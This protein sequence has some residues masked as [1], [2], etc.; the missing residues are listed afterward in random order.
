MIKGP[1]PLGVKEVRYA[2][3]RLRDCGEEDGEGERDGEESSLSGNA[4]K[5]VSLETEEREKKG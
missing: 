2:R 1:F 5:G 3:G 4:K